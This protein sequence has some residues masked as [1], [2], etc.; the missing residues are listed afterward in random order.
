MAYRAVLA[1]W[2]LVLKDNRG[3]RSVIGEIIRP[4]TQVHDLIALNGRGAR[5]DRVRPDSGPIIDVNREDLAIGI[6]RDLG[7]DFVVAGVNVSAEAF[8]TIRD[9]LDRTAHHL[10]DGSGR[11]LVGI[12]M[13]LDTIRPAD[14][15]AD[16]THA[17]FGNVEMF[18]KDGL[19]HMRRLGRVIRRHLPFRR[20][21]ID[22]DRPRFK[23]DTGMACGS[24][25]GGNHLVRGCEGGIDVPLLMQ[26]AKSEVVP[27]LGM[28]DRRVLVERR[29]RIGD[30][31]QFFV[32]DN[33]QRRRFFSRCACVC[34]NGDHWLT[35][36][37]GTVHCQRM[38]RR[39][40]QTLEVR[41]YRDPRRTDL[42]QIG[43]G[44]DANHPFDSLCLVQINGA[45][46]R[47]R[48]R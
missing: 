14:I 48:Q 33:H 12:D 6:H 15:A 1:G 41:Q 18:G 9:E 46:L 45:D 35:N 2:R 10:C 4:T 17:A 20:V 44:E 30:C 38:F 19:H 3:L 39:R 7:F 25:A 29:H 24:K 8:K 31:G 43:T 40:F 22:K 37:A 28:N 34:D 27:Q 23:R 36:P 11:H 21:P 32:I 16:D 13:H 47:M 42:S 26:A 5:I